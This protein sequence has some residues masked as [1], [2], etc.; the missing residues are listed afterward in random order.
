MFMNAVLETIFNTWEEVILRKCL[1]FW[2]F[3]ISIREAGNF[4]FELSAS[5]YWYPTVGSVYVILEYVAFFCFVFHKSI[6]HSLMSDLD[7]GPWFLCQECILSLVGLRRS[8]R[9]TIC[10]TISYLQRGK[11]WRTVTSLLTEMS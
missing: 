8:W 6:W 1:W 7:W 3:I 10:V 4:K 11:S 2:I 5:F 9:R